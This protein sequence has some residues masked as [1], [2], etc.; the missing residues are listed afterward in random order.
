MTAAETPAGRVFGPQDPQFPDWARGGG[1]GPDDLAVL[2]LVEP[3]DGRW[4]HVV[5]KPLTFGRGRVALANAD[6]TWEHW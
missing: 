5:A 3:V 2:E 1:Y 4:T 6:G